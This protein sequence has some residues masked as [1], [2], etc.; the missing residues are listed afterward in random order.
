MP[1][2]L[3]QLVLSLFCSRLWNELDAFHTQL[4]CLIWS[5]LGAVNFAGLGFMNMWKLTAF[6]HLGLFK[7]H[8]NSFN[9]LPAFGSWYSC[10][11]RTRAILDRFKT[12]GR[13]LVPLYSNGK[14]WVICRVSFKRESS[15]AT[16]DYMRKLHR[17]WITCSSR[18]FLIKLGFPFSLFNCCKPKEKSNHLWVWRLCTCRA[19]GVR[20]R[21]KNWAFTF[22]D[23]LIFN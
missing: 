19:E 10:Y 3:F 14:G 6:G 23:C 16:S 13:A 18:E 12:K 11:G 1:I 15:P 9:A 7:Q 20:F 8:C 5:L 4:S 21:F 2:P 17:Q 22:K